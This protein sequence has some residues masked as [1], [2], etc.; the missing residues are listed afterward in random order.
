MENQ[1]TI[2][3]SEY[4]QF[5][6]TKIPTSQIEQVIVV[7][8]SGCAKICSCFIRSS[9]LESKFQTQLQNLLCFGSLKYED[10]DEDTF[11]ALRTIYHYLLIRNYEIPREGPHWANLGFQGLN[12]QT[13]FR[14]SGLLS[15]YQ[16]L[17]FLD[18]NRQFAKNIFIYS[19]DKECGFPFI[20]A[21]INITRIV[22]D[23]LR[24]G[25]F[26]RLI[27][28]YKDTTAVA[29]MMYGGLWHVLYND[30]KNNQRKLSEFQI[31]LAYTTK[32]AR[33]N[34]SKVFKHF[35]QKRNESKL[36]TRSLFTIE[37][38]DEDSFVSSRVA[39]EI[40]RNSSSSINSSFL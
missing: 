34:C 36:R 39:V 22:I 7:K 2:S 32:M 25:I 38:K 14:S 21:G 16:M 24:D 40:P 5:L 3:A 20:L 6:E 15:V 31:S 35:L 26:N 27:T 17:H 10:N 11:A 33:K 8:Q 9:K 12:P 30:L 1:K 28:E 37:E 4:Y 18:E 13:D 29:N 23:C 19:Q